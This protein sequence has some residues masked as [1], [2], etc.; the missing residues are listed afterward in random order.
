VQAPGASALGL[1]E[2]GVRDPHRLADTLAR[3]EALL[4]PDA[5]G[6]PVRAD[7]HRPDVFRVA[8]FEV[9]APLPAALDPVAGLPPPALP[10]RRFR[11]PITVVVAA[12]PSGCLPRPLALLSGPQRGRISH[13][14]GPFPLSGAWWE[15]AEAWQRAE[16]DIETDTGH[17]LRLAFL[18]PDRWL[19]EGEYG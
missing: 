14:R 11:P 13:H 2:R 17:L 9:G 4:G 10:L 5:V 3:L 1:F 16:W 15:P 8:P 19:L 6:L 12:E 7:S 18:P